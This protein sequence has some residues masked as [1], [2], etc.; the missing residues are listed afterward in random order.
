MGTAGS[1][2]YYKVV[3]GYCMVL[4]GTVK[5][6]RVLQGTLGAY[7]EVTTWVLY[8]TASS[9]QNWGGYSTVELY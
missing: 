1:G 6:C 3:W 8:S 4:W 9:G 5:Y 7:W 2:R